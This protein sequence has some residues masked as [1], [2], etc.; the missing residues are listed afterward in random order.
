M[1]KPNAVNEPLSRPDNL[2]AFESKLLKL[3]ALHLVKEQ[4]QSDQINLLSR[5]GFKPAEI[6]ELVGTTSNTVRVCLS[7]QR[8]ARKKRQAKKAK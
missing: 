2:N 6:A 5:A 8:A 1:A 3:L 7:T 4:P